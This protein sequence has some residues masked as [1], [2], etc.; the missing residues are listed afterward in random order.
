M[1]IAIVHDWLYIYGG[2]ERVLRSIIKCFPQDDVDVFTL[3][4]VLSS[5]DKERIGI[6]KPI[7]TSF[8]QRM[9][10]INK[11]HRLYLPLMPYAIEQFDFSGYDLVIS[12]SYAVA[13]GIITGPDQLHISYIHSPMRYAWDLQHQYLRESNKDKGVKSVIARALLHKMRMWDVRTAH[14]PNSIVANSHYVARR[15]HKIYGRTSTVIHPPVDMGVHAAISESSIQTVLLN[16]PNK[17]YF[18]TA[19][20]LVPYKNVAAIVA[21]FQHLPNEQLE[22]AGTGPE[23]QKLKS[24]AGHNVRFLGFITNETM[25]IKMAHAKAFIFGAEEDFGITPVEAQAQGTPVIAYGKGGVLETIITGSIKP[26]GCFFHSL[27]PQAIA[28]KIQDFLTYDMRYNSND[29]YANALRFSEE[30][31]IKQFTSHVSQC[32]TDF[33]SSLTANHAVSH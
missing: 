1:R 32:L 5:E 6:K 7:T 10:K 11:Y 16:S 20:R 9:P 25:N 12:S 23:L 13:K 21:A 29:C 33:N 19:S 31:F 15:I 28:A 8:L 3:F 24:M 18:F 4:D 27:E 26:T 14:G 2:A 22:V 30:R 17:T